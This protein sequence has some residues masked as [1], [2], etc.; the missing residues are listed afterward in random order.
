M[1]YLTTLNCKRVTK[2]LPKSK[3]ASKVRAPTIEEI[4]SW[5]GMLTDR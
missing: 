5:L 2:A 4:K 3:S 1:N